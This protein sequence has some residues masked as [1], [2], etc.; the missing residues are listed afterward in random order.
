MGGTSPYGGTQE[1]LEKL[2]RFAVQEYNNKENA[3]LEFVRVIDALETGVDGI[4]YDLVLEAVDG[5]EKKIYEAK[6]WEQPWMNFK[7]LDQFEHEDLI[8]R[9]YDY[10]N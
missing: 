6:V 1:E 8:Y 3:L 7:E 2:G 4:M 10:D 9:S 5:G